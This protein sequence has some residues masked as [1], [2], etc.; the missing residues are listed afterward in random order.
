MF[1]EVNQL[2]PGTELVE[3]LPSGVLL[4]KEATPDL[5]M[6]GTTGMS[7]YG[8][9]FREEYN[10]TL[11]GRQGRE[12]YQKMRRSDGQVYGTLRL[13]KTPILAARW[14]VAP[15]GERVK[16]K[17][18][19][20]FIHDALFRLP[21]MSF[22]QHLMEVLTM[23]DFGFSA[24]EEVWDFTEWRNMRV[25]YIKNLVQKHALDVEEFL[26]DD[27]GEPTGIKMYD[28]NTDGSEVVIPT[29]K[30]LVFTNEREG[31]DLSG[32]SVLRPAYKHWFYKE[33]LYKIDA[34]QKERHGIG[35]PLI[36]LPVGFGED[37]KR[38]ADEIGRNLRTNEKAHVVL[39]PNW[40]IE[41]LRLEGN[42][43]DALRSVEHH[44]MMIARS[45]LGQFMGADTSVDIKTLL[46]VFLKST[47]F[48][49][50]QVRDVYN[51]WLIPK[52]VNF[53]FSG[54]IDKMPELRVRRLGDTVD[55]RTISFAIR[56]FI[57]A[58]AMIPDDELEDWIRDEM[59]LPPRDKKTER[60]IVAEVGEEAQIAAELQTE[61]TSGEEEEPP[62]AALPRQAPANSTRKTPGSNGRVGRDGRRT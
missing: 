5:R 21:G 42:L 33:N 45:I 52:L 13:V 28:P 48:T 2:P 31:G 15:G 37:D 38:L 49:A 8:S 4:L 41:M 60:Q 25:A 51:K 40:K 23:M 59:D 55:W 54:K 32:V 61:D 47:R 29:D 6:I 12:I 7:R 9:M 3:V 27:R 46:E 35:I 20:A 11:M 14:Y 56:N 24:F 50:D 1:P 58:K 39:P 26:Y 57:G 30:L 22:P 53:N 44:D 10:P 34:I 19:A 16:D 43:T 62:Q 36:T 17:K 18:I